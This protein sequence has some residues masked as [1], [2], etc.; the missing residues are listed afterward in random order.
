MASAKSW[1]E[2][3][4]WVRQTDIVGHEQDRL[5]VNRSPVTVQK[6]HNIID[7]A[8]WTTFAF[9]VK[10]SETSDMALKM[11]RNALGDLNVTVNQNDKFTINNSPP[12]SVLVAWRLLHYDQVEQ[13]KWS[14]AEDMARPTLDFAVQYQLEVC[15]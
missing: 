2:D 5:T 15:I 1:H 13:R 7:I 6:L 3:D 12:D 8:R 14:L 4:A 11:F 10:S 9:K